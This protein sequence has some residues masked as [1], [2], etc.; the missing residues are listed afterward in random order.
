MITT[1]YRASWD[2]QTSRS[3]RH[4]SREFENEGDATLFAIKKQRTCAGLLG[5]DVW[6]MRTDDDAPFF[7]EYG[8][9]HTGGCIHT[10]M[11]GHVWHY[12]KL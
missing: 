8:R 11:L 9:Y 1:Y 6:K 4:Y 2:V 10:E 7:D 12:Y 5:L 3:T